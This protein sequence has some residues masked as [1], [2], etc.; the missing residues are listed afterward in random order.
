M[1]NGCTMGIPRQLWDHNSLINLPVISNVVYL[2]KGQQVHNG[3]LSVSVALLCTILG[4]TMG[5]QHPLCV[6]CVLK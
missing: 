4:V 3:P 5:S 1:D 6:Y 2:Y